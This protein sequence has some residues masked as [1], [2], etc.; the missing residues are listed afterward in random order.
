M[1]ILRIQK[2][3]RNYTCIANAALRDARLSFRARGLHHLLLSYPDNWRINREHLTSMATEGRDAIVKALKE[4]E[5]L[6]YIVRQ[7]VRGEGGRYTWESLVREAPSDGF[8]GDGTSDGFSGDGVLTTDQKTSDG[9]TSDGFSGDIRINEITITEQE[10]SIPSTEGEFAEDL[11]VHTE[12]CSL[13]ELPAEPESHQTS[14]QAEIGSEKTQHSAASP[15]AV[16][17][18]SMHPASL[19]EQRMRSGGHKY[20]KLLAVGLGSVWVGPG[21]A[22]FDPGLVE[23]CC[24]YLTSLE[25]PAEKNHGI[26]YL[27]NLIRHEDWA[28]IE[29]RIDEKLAR[30]EQQQARQ[31]IAVDKRV[32][33]RRP[34]SDPHEPKSFVDMTPEEQAAFRAE[35]DRMREKVQGSKLALIGEVIAAT[36]LLS[37]DELS[38]YRQWLADS[39]MKHEAI[40]WAMH[41][42][43]VEIVVDD[44]GRIIDLRKKQEVLA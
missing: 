29:L 25:K 8:S 6:G 24:R 43:S 33:V 27:K 15:P 2:H 44:E 39:V 38:K 34:N 4:L 9:E 12:P 10:V 21:W 22:D 36:A 16:E 5:R 35:I 13:V 26:G 42:P 11:K 31:A 3:E 30:L 37:Q 17:N 19:T 23:A 1:S 18:F 28:A 41:N 20:P 7:K 14:D 32:E 40:A